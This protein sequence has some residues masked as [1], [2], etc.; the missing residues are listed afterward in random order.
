[1]LTGLEGSFAWTSTGMTLVS[2][3]FGRWQAE[4]SRPIY[5]EEYF[6]YG[7]PSVTQGPLRI[8][9]VIEGPVYIGQANPPIPERT[10][11]SITL[12]LD[13]V[14]VVTKSLTFSAVIYRLGEMSRTTPFTLTNYE[15][16]FEGT[17][18]PGT[19]FSEPLSGVS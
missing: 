10:V 9:G 16:G 2:A 15:Y 3:N 14:S 7:L 4:F 5:I 17:Y 18:S 1:M 8:R 19:P 11:G 12:T 13:G 6:G